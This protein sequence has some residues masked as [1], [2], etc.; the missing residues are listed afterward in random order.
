MKLLLDDVLTSRAT[1]LDASWAKAHSRLAEVYVAQ[2][3]LILAM[4]AYTKAISLS[5]D[6]QKK[7]YQEMHD[8]I[9]KRHHDPSYATASVYN[10]SKGGPEPF[11]IRLK[12]AVPDPATYALAIP[13]PMGY[14]TAMDRACLAFVLFVCSLSLDMLTGPKH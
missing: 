5:T 6:T 11:L 10:A 2:E 4:R 14:L 1:E 13:S 9:K 3:R 12:A 7:T 8:Q